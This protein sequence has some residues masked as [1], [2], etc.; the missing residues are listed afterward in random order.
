VV[1][2]FG[3][4]VR[5]DHVGAV[6]DQTDGVAELV[7]QRRLLDELLEGLLLGRALD[8]RLEHGEHAGVA[9]VTPSTSMRVFMPSLK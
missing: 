1:A 8:D 5:R 9:M 4:L 3:V 2:V 7:H 6:V